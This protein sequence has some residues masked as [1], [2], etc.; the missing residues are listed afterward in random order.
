MTTKRE[1]CQTW[2]RRDWDSIP[3]ALLE[4]A[5]GGEHYYEDIHILAPTPDDYAEQ[6]Y[7]DYLEKLEPF[8]ASNRVDP[9]LWRKEIEALPH[10]SAN[11]PSHQQAG[12][13]TVVARLEIVE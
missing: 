1:A 3:F 8:E 10:H 13:K 12:Q 2:I 6:Y 5:Y 7:E 11:Q 9:L 4:K